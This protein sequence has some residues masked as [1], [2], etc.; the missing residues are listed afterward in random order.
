MRNELKIELTKQFIIMRTLR[1]KLCPNYEFDSSR[2][3]WYVYYNHNTEK[4][5]AA[6]SVSRQ[7]PGCVYFTLEAALDVSARFN[8]GEIYI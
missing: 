6:S 5:T 7:I 8:S 4:W 2:S 3:N 1:L